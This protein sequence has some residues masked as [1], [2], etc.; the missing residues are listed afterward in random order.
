M[1]GAAFVIPLVLPWPVARILV[2]AVT[3]GGGSPYFSAPASNFPTSA[4]PLFVTYFVSTGTAFE[5]ISGFNPSF[6]NALAALA[7]PPA[8]PAA[9][10]SPPAAPEVP[11]ATAGAALSRPSMPG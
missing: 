7:S 8:A 6:E 4:P 1:G 9:E 11:A 3:A 2:A 5:T 10:E